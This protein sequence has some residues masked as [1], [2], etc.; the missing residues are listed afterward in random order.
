MSYLAKGGDPVV[1]RDRGLPS[2]T[3]PLF[4]S[5]YY[6]HAG[7]AGLSARRRVLSYMVRGS[8]GLSLGPKIVGVGGGAITGASSWR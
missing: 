2:F 6:K 4:P 1:G 8:A 7:R 3:L 5:T